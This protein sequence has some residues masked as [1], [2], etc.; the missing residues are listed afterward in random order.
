MACGQDGA[1]GGVAPGE[2]V[3]SYEAVFEPVTARFF[4]L[5]AYNEAGGNDRVATA[6]EIRLLGVSD[7]APSN[8]HSGKSMALATP[9]GRP[10]D[11]PSMPGMTIWARNGARRVNRLI[12]LTSISMIPWSWRDFATPRRS[13]APAG[14]IG[15]RFMS[16]TTA[17]VGKIRC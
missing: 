12:I 1:P 2:V 4:R 16:V 5:V 14:F 7:G 17:S 3:K 11:R 8:A 6:A 10:T 13:T 15:L 9:T